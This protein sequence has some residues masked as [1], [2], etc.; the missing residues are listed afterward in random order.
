M[1]KSMKYLI[2]LRHIMLEVSSVCGMKCD[3]CNSYTTTFEEMKGATEL[4]KNKN[5]DLKNHLS[6]K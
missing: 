3:S 1:S 2:P 5:T 4:T 6:I